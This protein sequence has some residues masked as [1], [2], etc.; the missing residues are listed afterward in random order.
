MGEIPGPRTFPTI[1]SSVTMNK[2]NLRCW[3]LK[4]GVWQATILVGSVMG[5]VLAA[6]ALGYFSGQKVGLDQA[7]ASSV[8]T[9]AR[10]PIAVEQDNSALEAAGSE[11]YAR[12]NDEAGLPGSPS[13]VTDE[14]KAAPGI[15][16]LGSIKTIEEAPL[17]TLDASD[18]QQF[19]EGVAKSQ[20]ALPGMD[21][22]NQG[23]GNAKAVS[24][25]E[26]VA[27]R[28]L[29]D[30]Q[31]QQSPAPQVTIPTAGK[32]IELPLKA[33]NT[34]APVPTTKQESKA[35]RL[36]AEK[37]EKAKEAAALRE[38]ALIQKKEKERLEKEKKAEE[39][40]AAAEKREAEAAARKL[41]SAS[42]PSS[43]QPGSGWYAQ[44]AAPRLKS[45][46]DNM[47][48]RL[49]SS[50]FSVRIETAKI[51]GEEY[52]RVLAGPEG[53]RDQADRLVGQ[54]KRESYLEGEPFVRMVK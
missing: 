37:A 2:Q 36:K 12:L 5:L 11:I 3:E 9:V 18:Q 15:P 45:D 33:E 28:V 32:A 16:E 22:L 47:A 26:G 43:S 14:K 17:P 30:L 39:R 19:A 38:A 20:A 10:L 51:R 29:G 21:L 42:V 1:K 40:K 23:L 13:A 27:V 54:L 53:S 46:A 24:G 8:A 6:F 49:R 34:I 31:V 7:L 4:V 50:G 44:V 35:E 48:R 52:Y 25:T 41:E